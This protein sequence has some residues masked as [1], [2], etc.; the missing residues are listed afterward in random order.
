[1]GGAE[2][3]FGNDRSVPPDTSKNWKLTEKK[4]G[5]KN[6]KMILIKK[7]MKKKKMTLKEATKYIKT[8]GLK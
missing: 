3:L 7:I 4:G 1:M 8:Q 6:I 2:G 5:S